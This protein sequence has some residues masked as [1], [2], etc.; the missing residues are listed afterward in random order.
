MWPCYNLQFYQYQN[1][2]VSETIS[3]WTPQVLLKIPELGDLLFNWKYWISGR[4]LWYWLIT[5]LQYIE[6]RTLSSVFLIEGSQGEQ[7]N[8]WLFASFFVAFCKLK[9]NCGVSTLKLGVSTQI[10]LFIPSNQIIFL[11]KNLCKFCEMLNSGI[12]MTWQ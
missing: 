2:I 6:A 9:N 4:I 1:F 10:W 8:W 7:T 3:Q 12:V 11:K 5:K